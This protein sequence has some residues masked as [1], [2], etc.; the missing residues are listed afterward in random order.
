[1][2]RRFSSIEPFRVRAV[3]SSDLKSWV[4]GKGMGIQSKVVLTTC[5]DFTPP[6]TQSP[7]PTHTRQMLNS[8]F[9]Y[10]KSNVLLVIPTEAIVA[11]S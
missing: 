11:P 8:S 4:P 9:H 1:M 2:N 10:H 6:A 3:M 7:A 5:F